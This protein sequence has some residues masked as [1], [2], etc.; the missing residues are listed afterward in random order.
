[1]SDIKKT[2]KYDSLEINRTIN[3]S[4]PEDQFSNFTAKNVLKINNNIELNNKVYKVK[5]I[6]SKQNKSAESVVYRVVDKE[7]NNYSLKLYF[8]INNPEDEPNSEALERI[9]KIL[10]PDILALFDFGVG[11]NKYL[12]KYCYEISKFALGGDLLSVDTKSFKEKYTPIFIKEKII[13]QIL[14]GLKIL[15]SKKIYHGDLKPSNIFFLDKERTDIVIGDYGAAKTF[16]E[17]SLKEIIFTMSSKGTSFYL[18]PEQA[19]GIISD[20]NDFY[21]FGMTLL[22][23]LYPEKVNQETL[24]KIIER[25]FS[26]KP[27]IDYDPKYK[28]LNTIIEGL[29]L[30]DIQN[31]WS[32]KEVENWSSGRG[33]NVKYNSQVLSIKLGDITIYNENDLSDYIENNTN[34]YDNLIKDK[35]G[36][37]I[38]LSFIGTYQNIEK[39]KK[40]HNMVKYYNR[41]GRNYVK[42]AILRYF[43][44]ERPIKLFNQ[45]FDFNNNLEKNIKQYFNLLD[46]IRVKTKL[47][48]MKFYIF[49]LEFK[50]KQLLKISN[51]DF[52]LHLKIILEKIH[53]SLYLTTNNN[54]VNNKAIYHRNLNLEKLINIFYTFDKTRAFKDLNNKTYINLNQLGIFFAENPELYNNEL[55]TTEKILFLKKSNNKNYLNLSYNNLIFKIFNIHIESVIKFINLKFNKKGKK[56]KIFYRFG[57]SLTKYFIKNKIKARLTQYPNKTLVMLSKFRRFSLTSNIF[58]YFI[59]KIP[60]IHKVEDRSINK[61]S[62][63]TFYKN[64]KQ[65]HIKIQSQYLKSIY[66]PFILSSIKF[67]ILQIPLFMGLLYILAAVGKSKKALDFLDILFIEKIKFYS[68][69]YI[70]NGKFSVLFITLLTVLFPILSV[71]PYKK[72]WETFKK[73][74]GEF[75]VNII[76]VVVSPI[77]LW[78]VSFAGIMGKPIIGS[79]ILFLIVYLVT[80]TSQ[81]LLKK[82]KPLLFLL[83][84]LIAIV[85]ALFLI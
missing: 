26:R 11:L 32:S 39:K 46:I 85:S 19:R 75:L 25:Q 28:E 36:Y 3:Y 30:Q 40:F 67:L 73:D 37:H 38:L 17:K 69:F 82:F 78:A 10:D 60:T 84:F 47:N 29:T 48:K 52:K 41:D 66:K 50:L 23:L 14:K 54:F 7:N 9:T 56:G 22:H 70:S 59:K 76:I 42:E 12:N 57:K 64:F 43:N 51:N 21:S 20:K 33:E 49:L 72:L 62:K 16:T 77:A 81:I 63:E 35:Q 65:T 79:C 2:E 13:P 55:L 44:P 83:T 24:R 68:F 4:S 45:A 18:A 5:E 6:I 74:K 71:L 1:M 80:S 15:H 8:F 34:W 58:K 31:R 53:S 61:E 27:I